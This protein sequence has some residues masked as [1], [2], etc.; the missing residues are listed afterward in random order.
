MVFKLSLPKINSSLMMGLFLMVVKNTLSLSN[1]LPYNDKVDVLLSFLAIVFLGAAIL[2]K[3]F[4]MKMLIIHVCI[5]ILALFS[6][7]QTKSFGI[8]ITVISCL[9]VR[10]ED[11][12]KVINFIFSYECLFIVV[13]TLIA[14][15]YSL[16]GRALYSNVSGVMRYNFGFRH[17][18]TFSAFLFNVIIMY[19]WKRFY[20]MKKKHI[21]T[22]L[23]IEIA[24]YCI[25]KS[26]TP[27]I[28]VCTVILLTIIANKSVK[29]QKVMSWSAGII[30][31]VL[32]FIVYVL[33]TKYEVGNLTMEKI[34]L[35]F[36]GRIKLGAYALEHYGLTWLGQEISSFYV[37]WDSYWRLNKFTFDNL[38]SNIM[39]NFGLIWLVI[40]SLFFFLLSRKNNAKVSVFLII[41]AIY[42]MS[43]VYGINVYYCFPILLVALLFEGK[44]M[45]SKQNG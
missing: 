21:L 30:V 5:I 32:A 29:M 23:G 22:I 2:K 42:G 44:V 41:W 33:I 11:I 28:A 17:P 14:F 25:T 7:L 16:L 36:S 10:D 19:I 40:C 27:F 8:L 1:I 6:V 4:T 24:V 34:N 35:L 45:R 18:N 9:A 39:I 3:K 15:G 26:L 13:H 38:Y 20:S 37:E 31:P 43:E 12:D